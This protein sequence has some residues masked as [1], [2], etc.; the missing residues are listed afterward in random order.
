[1]F[2]CIKTAQV[3]WWIRWWHLF[4][5]NL[6]SHVCAELLFQCGKKCVYL[7]EYEGFSS[8]Q[9]INIPNGDLCCGC[10]FHWTITT[11]VHAEMD[12][13]ILVLH[14]TMSDHKRD[15]VMKSFWPVFVIELSDADIRLSQRM[16]FVVGMISGNLVSW[17]SSLF[18]WMC[19]LLQLPILKCFLGLNRILVTCLIYETT[20]H[21]W[22]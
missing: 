3:R 17:E 8:E 16:C 20:H 14:L 5:S 1:M 6:G 10:R 15:L 2:G 18:R 4:S 12:S 21:T 9:S 19:S 11:Q 7:E 13:R 22:W